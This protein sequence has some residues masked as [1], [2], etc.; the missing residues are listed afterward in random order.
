M[1]NHAVIIKRE[2]THHALKSF[3]SDW[4]FIQRHPLASYALFLPPPL[5]SI[6]HSWHMWLKI[7]GDISNVLLKL[8]V[9]EY[10]AYSLGKNML[11]FNSAIAPY[12]GSIRKYHVCRGLLPPTLFIS[13]HGYVYFHSWIY[14]SDKKD[15][16]V[17]LATLIQISI[18][19]WLVWHLNVGGCHLFAL[20]ILDLWQHAP[21]STYW[22]NLRSL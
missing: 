22:Y 15:L 4:P 9:N 5:L 14:N 20:V 16:V 13:I 1:T 19:F 12:C 3:V 17:Y 11:V 18:R 10:F 6:K 7:L 21:Y 8:A 2:V